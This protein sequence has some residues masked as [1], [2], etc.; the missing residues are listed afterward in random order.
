MKTTTLKIRAYIS[1]GPIGTWTIIVVV[2]IIIDK[3][4]GRRP[5]CRLFDAWFH[6]RRRW[7]GRF[8]WMH[9]FVC[10]TIVCCLLITVEVLN[11]S[12]RSR[13]MTTEPKNQENIQQNEKRNE[14]RKKLWETTTRSKR[15]VFRFTIL[16]HSHSANEV[17]Y[18]RM[19]HRERERELMAMEQVEFVLSA[20]RWRP[21]SRNNARTPSKRTGKHEQ[22]LTSVILSLQAI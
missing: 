1:V 16:M 6:L 8:V 22:K 11:S 7:L 2:V 5:R 19:D 9:S 20:K 4:D 3:T 10:T 12:W 14:W 18:E 13:I 15:K 17:R 21:A